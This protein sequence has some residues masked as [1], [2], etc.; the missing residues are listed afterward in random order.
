MKNTSITSNGI[1]PG[2]KKQ[3]KRFIQ[4]L[5]EE[6][7]EIAVEKAGF[8][9][10]SLQCFLGRGDEYRSAMLEFSIAKVKELSVSNQFASEEVSS[11]YGYLSGYKPKGITEQTNILRQLIPG[12]GF[13]DEKLAE[14]PLPANAEG[15]FAIPKWQSV[16][17]TYGEAVQKV[18]DLIKKTRDGKFYNYREGQ[19]GPKNLRQSEKSAKIF[20]KLGEEQKDH[21][22]LVVAA[23][24]GILHRGRSVRRALEVMKDNQFGLGAF[25]VGI[26]I[27]THPER[28][29][30][31]DDLW[32]DCAGDEFSP[33]ADGVFGR[34]PRFGF[35][36]GRVR[37]G[38]R[39]VGAAGDA[40][41]SA[42]GF[43]SQ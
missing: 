31:Y 19:L 20:Q 25:A 38:A 37:F 28:L 8:N 10:D 34:A 39:W 29:Q 36:D 4:D 6:V 27:L 23:Q 5:N 18:L 24:F 43:V 35:D 16:A 21:D 14:Q 15:W 41:G 30:N 1:T 40:C 13:A 33:G 12:I 9:K 3:V 2:Q 26:M 7:A 11:K 32:I 42:S 17:P 22:I